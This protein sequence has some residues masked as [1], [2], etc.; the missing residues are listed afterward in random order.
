[1]L[2]EGRRGGRDGGRGG[3]G[4]GGNEQGRLAGHVLGFGVVNTGKPRAC[5]RVRAFFSDYNSF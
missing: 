4:G 1:M 2:Q 5:V 3:E